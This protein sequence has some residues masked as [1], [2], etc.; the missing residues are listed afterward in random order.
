M[1]V[2]KHMNQI[3]SRQ[4]NQ[5]MQSSKHIKPPLA[6]TESTAPEYNQRCYKAGSKDTM[7]PA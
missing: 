5:K 4:N 3:S 6:G 1:S 7:S 2:S